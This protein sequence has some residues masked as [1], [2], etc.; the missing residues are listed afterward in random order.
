MLSRA[1]GETHS[2][3][4]PS[5]E[6]NKDLD[7]QQRIL[8]RVSRTF[9][10]TIPALP[11]KLAKVVGNAY[12]L[13]RI[14]DTI[15][16]DPELS[17]AYK[18]SFSEQFLQ[19]VRGE[20]VAVDFVNALLPALAVQVPEAE[21]DLVLNTATV[22]RITHSFNKRQRAALERCV[23][24]MTKG[25]SKYQQQGSLAGL[26]NI[27]DMEQYCYYV[28]GV[29][30]EMLT[31]LFCDHSKAIADRREQLMSLAV[32][33]GLAL[34]MTNILKD[35]WEDHSRGACWLPRDVFSR[36][37]IDISSKSPAQQD[38]EYA[39]G[40]RELVGLACHH[41]R[42]AMEY[43]LLL[44]TR[45]TGIRRFCLLALIMAALTLRRINANPQFSSGR[46]VKISRRSVR[47]TM[48]LCRLFSGNNPALRLIFRLT[49]C[50]LPP[51]PQR[52][53]TSLFAA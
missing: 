24:V 7:Y 21:K 27:H 10:F 13:C 37:N 50:K 35:V 1:R 33:F 2:R 41:L 14:A 48:I 9:A 16:D 44:P 20:K 30:G 15:E 22:I 39:Q 8:Q 4:I 49:T 28:A 31:E 42:E 11:E 26:K 43:V 53:D 32:N 18:S 12:L 25:M 36:R 38:P 46:E 23:D 6:T 19:V 52:T 40:L 45:E 47:I 5:P 34:Q 17:A 51:C 29:V 3:D